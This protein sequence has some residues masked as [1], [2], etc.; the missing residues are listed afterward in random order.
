MS[1]LRQVGG[2]ASLIVED[3]I[4]GMRMLTRRNPETGRRW[5]G[6]YSDEVISEGEGPAIWH[7][8]FSQQMR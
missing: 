2:Y 3:H 6:I 4:T 1:A 7:S 8:Y 5:K